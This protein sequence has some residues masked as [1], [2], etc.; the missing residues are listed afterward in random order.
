MND[1]LEIK[2][3]DELKQ[4]LS[5]SSQESTVYKKLGCFIENNLTEIIFMTAGEIAAS[6]DVSQGSVTRFCNSLG[7]RGYNDFL[8]SL[9]VFVREEI[10]APQRLQYTLHDS[11]SI[12]EIIDM[13]Y[14]NMKQLEAIL[15]SSAYGSMVDRI[16][17]AKE[18]ILLSSRMSATLLPH[19]A[20][21]LNKIRDKVECITPDSQKWD[22]LHL[23]NPKEVQ[24][25]TIMFPRYPNNLLEKLKELKASGF[26]IAGVTDRITSP[27]F[28]LGKPVIDI[29]L[30]SSSIFDIYSTPMLF[31]NLLLRDVAKK[32]DGL[33]DRLDKLEE[34]E[35]TKNIYYK[36]ASH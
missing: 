5:F 19:I 31:F 15:S 21:I 34:Y 16:L 1:K 26:S 6:A 4:R 36:S 18:I 33:D 28:N 17:E 8:R 20:Y 22:T 7:Y 29:P 25:L 11:N 12:S 24:I 2:T 10:T 3:F 27:L 13:E 14:N 35:K 30:T 23:K 32:I 9:Q